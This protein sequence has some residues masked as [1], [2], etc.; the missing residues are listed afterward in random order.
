MRFPNEQRKFGDID[1]AVKL[2]PREKDKKTA[3]SKQFT[4]IL[5]SLKGATF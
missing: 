4:H 5:R 2:V 3:G 1:I